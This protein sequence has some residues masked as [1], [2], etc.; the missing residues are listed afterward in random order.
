M[1]LA[2]DTIETSGA[3]ILVFSKTMV[4]LMMTVAK[5]PAL[6]FESVLS[7][8]KVKSRSAIKSSATLARVMV[9]KPSQSVGVKTTRPTSLPA[10]SRTIMVTSAEGCPP[11]RPISS[12]TEPSLNIVCSS[13]KP[14]RTRPKL[15]LPKPKFSSVKSRPLTPLSM[16]M[17]SK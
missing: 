5:S 9:F 7:M 3:T 6:K 8:L 15:L 1:S 2:A 13:V 12:V 17:G 11:Q 4:S 14:L 10:R 16:T